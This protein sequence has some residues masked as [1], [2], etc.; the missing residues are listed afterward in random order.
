MEEYQELLIKA[1]YGKVRTKIE[2]LDNFYFAEDYH[3]DY[4]KKNPNGYC[5]DLSTGIVFN[6]ANKTLLNN[7]PLQKGK[8]ILV[9]DS[10]NYCHYC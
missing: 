6:D 1:G 5:P 2:P 3:Q 10:Q 4:L 7:E 8:K 9:L